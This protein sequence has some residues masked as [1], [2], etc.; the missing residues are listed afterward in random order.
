M[1]AMEHRFN[2][3]ARATRMHAVHVVMAGFMLAINVWYI[4]MISRRNH[5]AASR[6]RG[7]I[8]YI[9]EFCV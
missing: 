6:S 2:C 8:A 9:V 4:M 7:V 1:V 5:F 3:D